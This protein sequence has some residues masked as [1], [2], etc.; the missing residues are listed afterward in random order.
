MP[1]HRNLNNNCN[2]DDYC[3]SMANQY[4]ILVSIF[5]VILSQE[6]ENDE[7]LG[8]LGSFLVALGE[9]LALASEMRIA[10]KTKF[11]EESTPVVEDV[12][13]RSIHSDNKNNNRRVKKIKRKYIKKN[14]S[15][16][17]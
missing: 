9:E 1:K 6:I 7:D 16:K 14:K 12:F 11:N 5:S 15:S 13:D 17:K 10:C 4:L 3:N 2:I 8:I